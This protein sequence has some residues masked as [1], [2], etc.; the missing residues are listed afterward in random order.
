MVVEIVLLSLLI[1]YV[2]VLGLKYGY[3]MLCNSL[4]V[5]VRR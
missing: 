5:K 1:C 2:I 3:D 4:E